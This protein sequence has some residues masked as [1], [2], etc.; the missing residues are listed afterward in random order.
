VNVEDSHICKMKCVT[1]KCNNTERKF[2]PQLMFAPLNDEAYERLKV[3][4]LL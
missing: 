4:G 2:I 3:F 1:V